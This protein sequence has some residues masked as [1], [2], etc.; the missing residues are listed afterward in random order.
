MEKKPIKSNLFRFVTLRSPQLL[1]EKNKNFMFVSYPEGKENE[2]L[3][4]VAGKL[5]AA[6][7]GEKMENLKKAH[8][9]GFT[10]VEKRYDFKDS[11]NSLYYPF[12]K[13]YGFS[14]WLMRNKSSLSYVSIKMNLAGAQSL[15]S[16]NEILIWE[17]LFYQTI[18]KESN[19][20]REALIQ[21]LIANKFLKA[22]EDLDA[23]FGGL[24]YK[25]EGTVPVTT[26]E[27]VNLDD[28]RES[29]AIGEAYVFT[30][31]EE[32]E[33][34]YLASASVIIPQDVL[35]SAKNDSVPSKE[36]SLPTRAKEYLSAIEKVDKAEVRL[37]EYET[38]LKEIERAELVYTKDQEKKLQEAID[39]YEKKIEEVRAN[40][41]PTI[42]KE[43]DLVTGELIDVET[44]P[45]LDDVKVDFVK[46][47]ELEFSSNS[48]S[49]MLAR[50]IS[51]NT[52]SITSQL[53]PETQGLLNSTEF[54]IYDS[55]AEVKDSLIDKIKDEQQVI[56]DNSIDST[57]SLN[58]GGENIL[59]NAANQIPANTFSGYV[60]SN[61]LGSSSV[62]LMFKV[63]N[64]ENLSVTKATYAITNSDNDNVIFSGTTFENLLGFNNTLLRVRLF[65]E[66]IRL[67]T[68]TYKMNGEI[69]L[70]NGKVITFS[71]E[72]HI[73]IYFDDG[74][75]ESRGIGGVYQ[76]KG[77]DVIDNPVSQ[78]GVFGVTQLGIADFRRVEQE[79]CCYVPGEV[80]HIENI[81]AREY[82]ERSTRNL[83]VSDVTTETTTEREVEN[84]TDTTTTERNELQSETSSIVN[85]DTATSFGA[86]ASV[87]GGFGGVNF[88]AGTNFNTSSSSSVSNSN[89][90]AQSYAQEVTERALERVVEKIST[91]RTSRILKE[92]EENNTHGFDNRKGDEH[93][94]GVYRWVD[95]IYKNNLVNYGKRLMYEFAIPEPAKFYIDAYLSDKKSNDQD[96]SGLVLPKKPIHPDDLV[97]PGLSSG[98][99]S[100][101]QLTN[102][103][104]QRVASMYNAEVDA[105]PD[106]TIYVS[107]SYSKDDHAINDG[108]FSHSGHDEMRIPEGYE[109]VYVNGMF[110]AR[111]GNHSG[112]YRRNGD[113]V[114]GGKRFNFYRVD[115]KAIS[116]SF[117]N[118][119]IRDSLSFSVSSWD[120]GSYAYNL[121]GR[122]VLTKEAET[123]WQN[124]TY[125][126]IIDAYN[127]RLQ[128]YNDSL[129][130]RVFEETQDEK[131]KEF[132]SQL[133]RSIEKRELK[134]VAIHLMT[135]A[136][137]NGLTVSK[138]HYTQGNATT[139]SKSTGLD[140]H[141]AVVKFFEQV[142]DW[143]IM[144]YTFYPYFYKSEDNWSESFDYLDGNDPIFK[145]FLQSGMARSVVPVRP[146]FEDAVNWFMNTGEIWNGQ[147][148]VTDTED[149]LYL[150]VAEEM[151][152]IE[153]EVEGTWET[154]VPTA[155]TVLQAESVVLEEGGLP[156]NDDCNDNNTLKPSD[157]IIGEEDSGTTNPEGV[158]FDVVGES[159][160]VR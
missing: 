61:R 47:P 95:V 59:I 136:F 30:S 32:K 35:L 105:F 72:R 76:F 156:C 111:Q 157:T 70:S 84:L 103:N 36:I 97:L 68:T 106:R 116:T 5:D 66:Q 139:L 56:S 54:D 109:L 38:A 83:R 113:V 71:N 24:V 140:D 53:S 64:A 137:E 13:I 126:A 131:E 50:S 58:I 81:M 134:R 2:S 55:F 67:A 142:F 114:I 159:N 69:T 146:G 16:A 135:S 63:D 147:G 23:S 22:F 108:R 26:K 96:S 118:E 52:V 9:T 65:P 34:T 48:S 86:N 125:R 154:R 60:D 82:K 160:D 138:N 112:T 4:M 153:G 39:A 130:N 124:K 77:D 155:L 18:Q 110:T 107:K 132:S 85:E 133:N 122:C 7:S 37:G 49:D 120:V 41:S 20:V 78:S 40:T 75:L 29:P 43:K 99:K 119:G 42:V 15:S 94:T 101:S 87:S 21:I 14:N 17:N 151:Q 121:K 123:K 44:Y 28:G 51:T 12:S 1:N 45:E 144:A 73:T 92:Y 19:S 31:E 129:G 8:D 127:I 33:F 25:T 74:I 128:E 100:A 149:D 98:L 27:G 6:S 143:E 88:A 90:Q 93:V 46:A 57:S 148:I 115:Y 102:T 152:V 117:Y 158:S 3:A 11:K 80:S 79:V 89:L 10:P 104:Y 150:S 145:A 91:K 62:V 141:A